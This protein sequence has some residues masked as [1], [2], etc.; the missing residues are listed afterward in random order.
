[1]TEKEMQQ[2]IKDYVKAINSHDIKAIETF[3]APDSVSVSAGDPGHTLDRAARRRY[4]Q[5][6]EKAFPDAKMTARNIQVDPKKGSA[7]FDW[8][9]RGT[10]KGTFK[11]MAPTNKQVTNRGNTELTIK[12]GKITYESSRQDV[13]SFMKQVKAQGAGK[14][15]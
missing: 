1:M 5:E 6:R 9:I 11:G 12:N 3:H 4:F 13:A 10:H 15:P 8:T 14:R 2:F 7:S